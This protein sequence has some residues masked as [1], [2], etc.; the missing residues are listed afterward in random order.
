MGIVPVIAGPKEPEPVPG[1]TP[2]SL[3]P[4]TKPEIPLVKPGGRF[5]SFILYVT[6]ES[7]L[8][9]ICILIIP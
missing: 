8:N 5:C 9:D 3:P 1:S 2:G 6:L 4:A 7:E